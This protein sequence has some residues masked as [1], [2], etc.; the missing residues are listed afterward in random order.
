MNRIDFEPIRGD[1]RDDG[2]FGACGDLT[3]NL[4]F[5]GIP[6]G[7]CVAMMAIGDQ[8]D[9]GSQEMLIGGDSRWLVD[10]IEP[11]EVGVAIPVLNNRVAILDVLL[12]Q[13]VEPTGIVRQDKDGL[14]IDLGLSQ[15]RQPLVNGF[16][17]RSLMR[18][19]DFR[20]FWLQTHEGA[21]AKTPPAIRE[22]N[23]LRV[24]RRLLIGGKHSFS[25]PFLVEQ[26]RGSMRVFATH[27]SDQMREVQRVSM[28]VVTESLIDLVVGRSCQWACLTLI[29]KA[30]TGESMN[31]HGFEME[32]LAASGLFCWSDCRAL[33]LGPAV[34]AES[35]GRAA[36]HA[37]AR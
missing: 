9:T 18:S 25:E 21:E 23:L 24:H 14:Q 26:S 4:L 3:C 11:V 1:T 16:G 15:Q 37:E 32:I 30:G 28:Q 7:Y 22:Q 19:D 8:A 29:G 31:T 20:G 36:R 35:Q 6:A 13:F 27:G 17:H 10:A 2:Q 34:A 5:L 12:Q 33:I